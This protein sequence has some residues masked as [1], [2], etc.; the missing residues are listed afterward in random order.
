[1]DDFRKG[2]KRDKS[3]YVVLK[4]DKQWDT[5][6]R[7]TLATARSHGCEQVFDPTYKPSTS[8]KISVFDEKQKFIYSVFEEKLK[9]D[10]SK[11]YV[12]TYL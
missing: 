2:I 7:S 5:W 6:K 8:D 12:R 4:E 9:T 1:M 10:L 11:F 3:H